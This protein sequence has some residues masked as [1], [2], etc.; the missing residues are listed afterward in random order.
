MRFFVLAGLLLSLAGPCAAQKLEIVIPP[1]VTMTP[2]PAGASLQPVS[3]SKAVVDM[4]EGE[5]W[6]DFRGGI[7]CLPQKSEGWRASSDDLGG[8]SRLG[9]IFQSVLEGAG[10]KVGEHDKSDLFASSTRTVD[11][12][13]GA[14]ISAIRARVC[15]MVLKTKNWVD[16]KMV[17]D[18]EWQ[19]YSVS[20]NRVLARIPT[21]GGGEGHDDDSEALVTALN[22]AFAESVRALAASDPFRALV[23]SGP[24]QGA[25]AGAAPSAGEMLIR[26]PAPKKTPLTQVTNGVV[27]V[28]AGGG[29]GSGLLISPD[30]YILTNHHVAGDSGQV[31]IRWPDGTDTIGEVLRGDS[32]RDVTLVRTTAKAAPLV[33]RTAAPQIGETVFAIGTPL[34]KDLAGT[35]TRGVVSATRVMQGQPFI[36]SD[37]A[38]THGNS[39]GPL[40]D[41]NGQVLGMTVSGRLADDGAAVNINF[42]IPIDDA[43]RVLALKPAP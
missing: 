3:L 4:R 27:S 33:I 18:I 2:L 23:M 12:Q 29:H 37:V 8:V 10:F 42:F 22:K 30:G 9:P 20:Q 11:L 31:R 6:L 28:F 41:E 38:V 14:R 25:L 17:V 1:P 21:R 39:G 24:A 35:L 36:Q 15:S 5:R 43:L 13:M 34:D 40:V 16:A 19:V 26:M 7:L 32:R